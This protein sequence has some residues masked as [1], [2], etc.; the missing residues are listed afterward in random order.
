MPKTPLILLLAALVAGCSAEV[1][2]AKALLTADLAIPKDVEF[3]NMSRHPGGSVCGEYSAY[4]DHRLPKAD[5]LPFIVVRG[6]LIREPEDIQLDVYCSDKPAV[7]LYKHTG[8]G[9]F[10]DDN[11][12]LFKLTAD[13]AAIGDAIEAYYSDINAFPTAEQGLEALVAR[14]EPKDGMQQVML[15]RYREGGYLAALPLDPWGQPY[16][17]TEEQW[18]RTRGT[19]E[20]SSAGADQAAGGEDAATDVGTSILPYLRHVAAALGG[21]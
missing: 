8:V 4:Y 14:P 11:D 18:G 13:L 19:Y 15:S 3:R 2:D 12:A 5:Y 10:T 6:E 20:V 1:R 21:S 7:A 9:P 17:Y 16:R